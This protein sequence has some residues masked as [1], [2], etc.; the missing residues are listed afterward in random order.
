MQ[1]TYR[2]LRVVIL[3]SIGVAIITILTAISPTIANPPATGEFAGPDSVRAIFEHACYDCHSN[4]TK[5]EWYAKVAPLSWKVYA[6]VQ[7]ARRHLN[8]SH[9]DSLSS[10]DQLTKLWY[11]V[12][13]VEQ[14]KMP[15]RDYTLAHPDAIPTEKEVNILKNY[16]L[17]LTNHQPPVQVQT[18]RV[19]QGPVVS[20]EI[21]R[22]PNGI[23]YS[24]DYRHWKV[25]TTTNRFDNGTM[26]IIYGN[27]IAVNAIEQHTIRPWPDGAVIVKVVWN[28]GEED[29]DGNIYPGNFSNVQ[30]M[31]R[32]SRKFGKTEGWGF[33]RFSTPQLIPYGATVNF[34]VACID[35]HR[36]ASANGF[37]FD[38]PSHKTEE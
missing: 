2:N 35:C 26:R 13:M 27:D 15:R 1:F 14:G 24:S 31:I 12:N 25:I 19:S 30:F 28:K 8:F 34:D 38:V 22:S 11:I 18:R 17:S 6:D 29:A 16:V 36:L 10:G 4:K 32:D 5:Q 33:A 37:V 9:W 7:E 23:E 3:V 20:G 21:K